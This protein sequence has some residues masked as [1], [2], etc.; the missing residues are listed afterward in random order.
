MFLGNDSLVGPLF[1]SDYFVRLRDARRGMWGPTESFDRSYHL[2]SSHLLLSGRAVIDQ[3]QSFF[4]VYPFY[5]NRTNIVKRG[6]VS[7][8]TWILCGQHNVEAFYPMGLL[9]SR[10]H[11]EGGETQKYSHRY[12]P[13]APLLRFIASSG[14]SV[15]KTRASRKQSSRVAECIV[16][17]N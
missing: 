1:P 13:S 8:S 15:R 17:G 5:N 4:N 7:L 12:K 2:Q 10:K 14:L 11:R 16:Q 3:A 9:A 6:E